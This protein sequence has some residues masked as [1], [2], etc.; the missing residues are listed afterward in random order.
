VYLVR[1]QIGGPARIEPGQAAQFTATATMSDGTQQDYTNKVNWYGSPSSIV[2]VDRQTGRATGIAT[3]KGT[4]SESPT[5]P[6]TSCCAASAPVVVMPANT[7]Q[8]TGKVLESGLGLAGALVS[9]TAG[10]GTGFSA[11]TDYSG[12]YV[13]YGVADTIDV[14]VTKQGYDAMVKTTNVVHDDVLD[15]P[16]AHQTAALPSLAGAYTLTM[17]VDAT[18]CNARN[19]PV[20]TELS[21]T[22]AYSAR[23]VQDGASLTVTLTD[24]TIVPG[25]DHFTGHITPTNVV[26]VMG[27][28][29]GYY[30]YAVGDGVID[31]ITPTQVISYTG[32][33]LTGRSSAV[34]S[35]PFIGTVDELGVG[36]GGGYFVIAYCNSSNHSFTLTPAAGS[37]RRR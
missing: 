6:N 17:S 25:N 8:L 35:S 10:T 28:G 37:L 19:A 7:F 14:T 15:F 34:I 31:R 27:S 9:V 18:S 29:S 21:Q 1:L 2:T 32:S 30:D 11:T 22:R 12:E 20:P 13:L 4:V 23:I 26:F 24:A 36:A 16:E 33:V 5:V 3:G